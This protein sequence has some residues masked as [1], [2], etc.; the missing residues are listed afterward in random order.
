[1]QRFIKTLLGYSPL[2]LVAVA[3][4][5]GWLGWRASRIEF[6]FTL[7]R[8]FESRDEAMERYTKFKESFG[9]DD[10]AL[11]V[12]YRAPS[13]LAPE[14]L[15]EV[16]RIGGRLSKIE[17]VRAVFGLGDAV[18]FL[19]P[20]RIPDGALRG[21]LTSNP[22][23]AGS[24]VSPDGRT[25]CLWVLLD[26]AARQEKARAKVIDAVRAVLEEEERATGLPLHLAGIPA[27]ERE[28]TRLAVRDL[29]TFTPISVAT[30]LLLLCLYFR[31]VLGTVLP[32]A[33][34]GIAV[35][36]TLGL[37][38]LSG[39]SIGVLT[40][41][42]PN[43]ILVIGI[44]DAI[45]FLSRYQEDLRTGVSKRDALATTTWVMLFACFLTAFTTSIG[46]ASL[47]TTKVAIVREFG[48]VCAVGFMIVYVVLVT[49]LPGVLDRV[50]PL[51]GRVLD[52]FSAR[53]SDRAM[54]RL[55]D[56]NRR[57]WPWI[58]AG[59]AAVTAVSVVFM[60]RIERGSS[61]L[62]DIRSDNAVHRAHAFLEEH[63]SPVFTIDLEIDGRAPG[64]LRSFETL[65]AIDAFE[66]D[67]RGLGA[68]QAISFVDLARE[69]HRGR[70][71]MLRAALGEPVERPMADPS[72]RALPRTEKEL[73]GALALLRPLERRYD[74]LSR[75]V[76]PD[77]ARTRVS[78]R[79]PKLD[80]KRL[81]RFL[82]DVERLHRGK[83]AGSF[84][85]VATGKSVLAKRAVD[86]I[87]G[88]MVSSLWL[89]GVLI[90]GCMWAL[91]QSVKVGLLSM[92]PNFVPMFVTAGVMGAAGMELNF[93]TATI[94]SISLGIAVDS[95]IHYLSRLRVELGQD[96]PSP[97]PDGGSPE[98]LRG[99]GADPAGAMRRALVGAGRPMIFGTLLLVLG[100]A[101]ILTSNFRF[102][103]NFGLLGGIT[104]LVALACDLTLTPTLMYV[105]RPR[106][107]RW[108]KLEAHLRALQE[109]LGGSGD[110]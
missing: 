31:N 24:L 61:W 19:K 54:E 5:T 70:Q 14:T 28:Y 37:M 3:G 25:G 59:W 13:V 78:V 73:G 74:M 92:I 90:F 11:F 87:V 69:L 15:A 68:S 85:M 94:F 102:T 104:M 93:S 101:S 42:V 91:F 110:S 35:V 98:R 67:L 12:G 99:A 7:E 53:F 88:N 46:F 66:G 76:S 89:A 84:A 64:A 72:L 43:L 32:L 71:I 22:L 86:D 60:L 48:I 38:E 21:E 103:F 36:W 1:M 97:S 57:R 34:V 77:F 40:S 109:K 105:A 29:L 30:F 26:A 106:V 100:F 33:A 63:L 17:H 62:Q 47:L 52:E 6:D 108:E 56:F 4:L 82:G 81:E 83:Y 18:A 44:A 41:I 45:H 20:F 96:P 75:V 39:R 8:L 80:S 27:I 58:W 65:R 10:A 107:R 79:V 23:F 55:A 9:G 95:T 16:E 51:R 49:F 2:A 50:P